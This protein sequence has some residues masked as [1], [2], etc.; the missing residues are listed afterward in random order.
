VTAAT[1]VGLQARDYLAAVEAELADLPAEDRSA[2]L[3]D[4]ALHL[5]ALAAEE[6]DRPLDVRLGAPA[7]YAADLRVAA[8]LP[9]RATGPRPGGAGLRTWLDRAAPV[10]RRVGPVVLA[11][12][13]LLGELRPAWWVLRGYLVVLLLCVLEHDR[14]RDFPVPAPGE[15][16]ALGVVLV[17]AAV[18]GSVML[19]RRT[20]PR[21]VGIAVRLAGVVLVAA[22][23]L[24]WESAA[25]GSTRAGTPTVLVQ[26]ALD[27]AEGQYPLLSR[28]GPVTDVL[29]YAADG[30]P[31]EDVLL[32]D[33]DGRPLQVGK[34]IWWADGCPR[35]LD[36]PLAEDGVPV[37]FA[38]PQSYVVDRDWARA[39][40][41]AG[42]AP[43]CV[44]D[45][46]RPE[47]PIPAFP[48]EPTAPAPVG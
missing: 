32:F 41:G 27:R 14:V 12:R 48:T 36:Q 21:A 5:D 45:I 24:V 13:R 25:F 44:P 40:E 6:D 46:P 8:G 42:N 30:T 19:G 16:H 35:V 15:S 31:L 38:F 7:A 29:P 28:Y 3:E 33:Q 17:V 1:G 4:L 11:T 39:F 18:A 9:A 37:A 2:L 23:F 22:S 43:G 34:Q 26:P 10:T 20:L 47:V